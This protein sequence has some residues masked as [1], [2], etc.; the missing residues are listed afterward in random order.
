[1]DGRK[2][3]YFVSGYRGV[4]GGEGKAKLL[5]I[6][7]IITVIVVSF[8]FVSIRSIP[9]CYHYYHCFEQFY[10]HNEINE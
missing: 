2:E 9:F 8:R 5:L 4:V 7:E 1:M 6:N 3:G 10:L